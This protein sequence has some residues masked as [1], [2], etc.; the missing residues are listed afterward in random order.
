MACAVIK[1]QLT[2]SIEFMKISLQL[3]LAFEKEVLNA[4]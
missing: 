4:E 1:L 3:V 2:I